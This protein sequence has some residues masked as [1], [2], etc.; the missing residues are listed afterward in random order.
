MTMTMTMMMLMMIASSFLGGCK[1]GAVLTC[2][3]ESHGSWWN[4]VGA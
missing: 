3:L 2:T 1:G 4:K